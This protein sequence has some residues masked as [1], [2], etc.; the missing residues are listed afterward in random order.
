MSLALREIKSVMN[1]K[2][3]FNKNDLGDWNREPVL[4]A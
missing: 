4:E 2:R 3:V 1:N